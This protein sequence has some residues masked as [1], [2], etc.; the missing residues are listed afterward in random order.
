MRT[1]LLSMTA[2][3]LL[4]G[5]AFAQTGA[6][7]AN[8]A[9][10]EIVR[11]ATP[12]VPY[13]FDGKAYT[14]LK[15]ADVA[16]VK[17]ALSDKTRPVTDT[18]RDAKRKPGEMIGIAGLHPGATVV[19]LFPGGGYFTRIFAKYV[20][21]NGKVFAVAPPG[22]D[23]APPTVAKIAAEPGYGNVVVTPLAMPAMT[24]TTPA[25]AD[26]VWTSRNYHDQ[27]NPMRNLDINAFNK[28][29]LDSLK[30]GGTYIVLDHASAPGAGPD[31]PGT[32]HRM[33]PDQV[34]AEVTAAGFQFVRSDDTLKNP[35]DDLNKRVS[36]EAA[37]D[38][39][40]QF[41]LV[42]RKPG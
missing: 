14:A 27:R 42:F 12:A 21:P 34:K 28:A 9:P 38:I 26:L 6:P 15:A 5:S 8:P 2:L 11:A 41:I 32:L 7:S 23:G 16:A 22:R 33:N 31:V 17:A 20:G 18:E 25:K 37:P 39:S 10:P 36:E 3:S 13:N 30:P 1:L 29:V 19:E 24:Y 35:A 4:A 40:S